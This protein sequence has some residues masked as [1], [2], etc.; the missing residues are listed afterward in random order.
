MADVVNKAGVLAYVGSQH[1]EY[2]YMWAEEPQGIPFGAALMRGTDK[3]K[4]CKLATGQDAKFIGIA[5]AY[6]KNVYDKE[7]YE[8]QTTVEIITKGKV[9]VKVSENVEAGDP[10]F[11]GGS[12]GAGIFRKSDE[13]SQSLQINAVYETKATNG[14]YA[15]LNLK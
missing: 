7:Q 13:G 5:K 4:Q 15:I 2:A 11:V 14:Q 3:E 8:N 1:T 12:S 6:Q 10:V 9:W